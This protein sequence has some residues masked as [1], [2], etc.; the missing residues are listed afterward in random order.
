[1][2]KGYFITFEGLDGAG[3]TTQVMMLE[4]WLID[5][6]IDYIRTREPGGTLLGQEIRTLLFERPNIEMDAL[7][8]AF[9]FAADRSTHFAKVVIPALKSGKVVISDRCFDSNIAYQ[10]F[11]RGVGSG[12]VEH[13]NRAAMRLR[14]P[15]LTI[16]L[17]L[18]PEKVAERKNG[19]DTSRFDRE[20]LDFHQKLRTVFLTR[21][22]SEPRRIK[23]IDATQ[24]IQEV[25]LKIV[26]LVEKGMNCVK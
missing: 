26:Q 10:G 4:K 17:D 3:K 13:I 12:F 5:Q 16:L 1:M 18:P 2:Q 8:E 6:H 14:E 20:T 22:K 19:Q 21:A 11:L 9:L 24:D 25:H 15:H 23:V 7:T